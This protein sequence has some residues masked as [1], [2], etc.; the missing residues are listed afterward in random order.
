[1]IP[2]DVDPSTGK[3]C[4]YQPEHPSLE[5]YI[6]KVKISRKNEDCPTKLHNCSEKHKFRS[7]SHSA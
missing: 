6:F 7:P 1:M 5:P 2:Q 3:Y 4:T